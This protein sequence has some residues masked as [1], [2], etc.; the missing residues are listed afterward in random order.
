MLKKKKEGKN[1]QGFVNNSLIAT[2]YI[3]FPKAVKKNFYS[4]DENFL[5]R[6]FEFHSF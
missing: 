3:L 2:S 4:I 6:H 1:R 5:I